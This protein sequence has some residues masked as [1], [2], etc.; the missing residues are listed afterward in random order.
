ML[1]RIDHGEVWVDGRL[2]NL[3]V[4]IR[5]EKVA[6]FES[7]DVSHTVANQVI[8]ASGCWVL[9]GG[10]D[11]HAH[12]SD[13]IETI[14]NG[15]CCAA[16]GGI[17]SVMDMAPFHG[18]ITESQFSQKVQA[19]NSNAVVDVGIIAG[20]VV[21]RN[22]LSS[23]DELAR[24][25]AAYFKVFQPADPAVADTTLRDAVSMA[26]KTG[27]R[28]GIHAENPDYFISPDR[29]TELAYQFAL[30]RPGIAETNAISRVIEFAS[31][32]HAPIHICHISTRES[33]RLVTKA[34]ANGINISAEVT[35]HHLLLD[36]E[37][38]NK[39][40]ARVKTTPPLRSQEDLE[41][42]WQAVSDGTID[43][44]VSDHYIENN[45]GCPPDPRLIAEAPAG[46][47][48]LEITLPLIFHHVIQNKINL[49]KF[50]EI[51]SENPARLAGIDDRKG[52]ISPNMD[53]D[54]TIWN[55]NQ[56][57]TINPIGAFSRINT[58]PY[59]GWTISGRL[60]KTIVRGKL[61]WNDNVIIP[62]AGHGRWIL[63]KRS[64]D[65]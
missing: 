65:D 54:L 60:Q 4:L 29:S 9:P 2:Q 49:K 14:R 36:I 58:T 1:I 38:F 44:L 7:S 25:G 59:V 41:A 22:D 46:I 19:I 35:P 63:S 64:T 40:G 28:L 3:S 23:L 8:D 47:A 6:G 33:A 21:D 61:I 45:A 48:G 27:L 17:T 55:P 11:L 16:A 62:T 50:V 53:A 32:M 24:N 57:W 15:T 10:I 42:L 18:C 51:T 13:G 26:A 39:Y 52:K 5:D 30:S 34:R 12:I 43:A 37:S 31:K 56:Q 20:I